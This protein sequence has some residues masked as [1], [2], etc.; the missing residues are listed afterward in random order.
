MKFILEPFFSEI[1]FSEMNLYSEEKD[2]NADLGCD[3]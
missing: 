2:K 1:F 3:S